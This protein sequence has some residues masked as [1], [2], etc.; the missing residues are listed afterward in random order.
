MSLIICVVSAGRRRGKTALIERLIREFS[1]KGLTVATVKHIRSRFDTAEKD[2][3]KHLRAG[4]E[5]TIAS[6]PDGIVSISR[7]KD[8]SLEMILDTIHIKT[9]LILV[10]GYKESSYPKIL[11][12]DTAEEAQSTLEEISEVVMISGL[13]SKDDAE[14]E[15]F[16]R[17]F[18]EPPVYSFEEIVLAFKKMLAES[19]V[20]SLPGLNCEKCSYNSC[21]E[22]AEAIVSGKAAIEDCK[23][24]A[25]NI[26]TLKVDGKTVPLGEFPQ[27]VI[28]SVTLGILDVLKGAGNHPRDIE[29]AV[30]ADLGRISDT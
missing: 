24:Q 7:S 10:E 2:T 21:L 1:R 14:K 18:Q 6:T 3:W 4:A 19:I 16:E 12:A 28:R 23:V 15:K 13:I 25:T 26:A 27:Q 22:L 9:E 30:K 29:I 8:P 5:M 11:C 20:R 17:R